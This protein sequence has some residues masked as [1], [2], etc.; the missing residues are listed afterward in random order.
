VLQLE[1]IKR[2]AFE[3]AQAKLGVAMRDVVVRDDTDSEGRPSLHIT[4][5]LKAPW[6]TNPPGKTLGEISLALIEYLAQQGD[7][8]FPYTHYMTRREYTAST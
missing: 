3:V 5:I 7:G 8:R 2:K 6:S 4:I 1:E